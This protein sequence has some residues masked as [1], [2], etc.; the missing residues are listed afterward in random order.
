M[1]VSRSIVYC[2]TSTHLGRHVES[3]GLNLSKVEQ[4]AKKATGGVDVVGV[5]ELNSSVC[6]MSGQTVEY[7]E[8]LVEF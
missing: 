6:A 8:Y 7:R 3:C 1:A 2:G 4:R 5:E